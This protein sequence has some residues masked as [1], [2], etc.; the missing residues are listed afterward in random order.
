MSRPE[1][2]DSICNILRVNYIPPD[3]QT[4]IRQRMD[5]EAEAA[6]VKLNWHEGG[7]SGDK[8]D[9]LTILAVIFGRR[10]DA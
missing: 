9:R 10:A 6:Q 5:E 2:W 1:G 3:L 7:S 4:L 8:A